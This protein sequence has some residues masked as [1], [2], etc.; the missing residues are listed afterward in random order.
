MP[1]RPRPLS[2]RTI[3]AIVAAPTLVLAAAA[4]FGIPDRI[5]YNPSH[6]I[7]P[8]FYARAEAPV[9]AGAIVT[10]RTIDV[11][12]AYAIARDFADPGD[13]FI[14]RVAAARGQVVCARGTEISID[15]MMVARRAE[16]DS[17]G[18]LLPTWSGCR[19]LSGDEVFLLGDTPD[20]FDGRYWGPVSLALIEGV[21]RPLRPLSP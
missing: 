19:T 3:A 4:V 20:S 6:S 9:E 7:P 15:A 11:A 8:G 2:P 17:V 16:R 12:G 21:W 1:V 13:R 14:K 10:V 5:L 18:R